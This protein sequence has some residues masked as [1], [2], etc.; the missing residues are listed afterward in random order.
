MSIGS[1]LS[2][3]IDVEVF[4]GSSRV[5]GVAVSAILDGRFTK[6]NRLVASHEAVRAV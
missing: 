5:L 4:L 2:T 1:A 6:A 3:M